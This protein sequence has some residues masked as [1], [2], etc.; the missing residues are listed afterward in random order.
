MSSDQMTEGRISSEMVIRTPDGDNPLGTVHHGVET[1]RV[2]GRD[3][4]HVTLVQELRQG[5]MRDSLLIDAGTLEPLEYFNTMP[6]MQTIHT[7]YGPEGTVTAD[8]ERGPMTNR[9]DSV[10]AG[11]H[12]DA[13]SFTSM[14]SAL[15]LAVGLDE[16]YPVFH[17]E[18]G[19][20]AYRVQ[21]PGEEVISTCRGQEEAWI[22]DVTTSINTTRHW[23][24][25]DDGHL[26]R[27]EVEVGDGVRFEQTI[28]C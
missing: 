27:V 22:V 2:E 18:E 5:T 28:T 19:V 9:I 11:P 14:L 24:S 25:Q 3:V 7:V 20:S 21:V 13:A 6:G 10:L 4:L 12:L 16:E 26:V 1:G 8:L 23:I 15:P 17:Y